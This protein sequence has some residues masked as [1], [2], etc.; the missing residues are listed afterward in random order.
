MSQ[1][2]QSI[3]PG[4]SRTELKQI[5]AQIRS[6]PNVT[7][8]TMTSKG[9]TVGQIFEL[10]HQ[11]Q[12]GIHPVMTNE[13]IFQIPENPPTDEDLLRAFSHNALTKYPSII[14]GISL[15]EIKQI[16]H[17]IR[18]DPT[19][20]ANTLTST[21]LTVGQIMRLYENT[22]YQKKLLAK[23]KGKV[24]I[25]AIKKKVLAKSKGRLKAKS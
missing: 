14:D 12:K 23:S 16:L 17:R 2:K 9:L 1:V 10:Y 5:F 21:G 22:C 7:S 19:V 3:I 25:Q 24:K 8:Q 11:A 13:E 18:Y 15:A 20:T 4:I 6:D